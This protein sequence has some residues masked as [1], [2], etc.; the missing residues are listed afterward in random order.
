MLSI[1]FARTLIWLCR[2]D[3][4]DMQGSLMHA[5]IEGFP[6]MTSIT[7]LV[8]S[9]SLV[10]WS[11]KELS[12]ERSCLVTSTEVIFEEDVPDSLPSRNRLLLGCLDTP[13]DGTEELGP[14]PLPAPEP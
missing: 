10:R 13:L 7:F 2:S 14:R 3:I 1:L 4:S 12:W 9:S 6:R 5:L 11:R 8:L